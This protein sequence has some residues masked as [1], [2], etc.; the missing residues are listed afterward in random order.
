MMLIIVIVGAIAIIFFIAIILKVGFGGN[1]SLKDGMRLEAQGKLHE[2][3]VAYD[4]IL[5]KGSSSPELRWKIANLALK[6]K[7]IP[8]AQ[9]E[10]NI[11]LGA[12]TLPT[13][14]SLAT[15]KAAM[16]S[17]LI[18]AGNEKQ[19]FMELYEIVKIDDS[20]PSVFLDLGKIYCKQ[21][22]SQKGI[23]LIEKYLS[24]N[25]QDGE[26]ALFLGLAYLDCGLAPK[27]I[28]AFEKALRNKVDD[29]GSANY[30]LGILY[31]SQNKINLA[32][33]H[34]TQV[35]RKKKNQKMVTESHRLIGMCYKE[36]G[37]IDEAITSFE[38]ANV[39]PKDEPK[40]VKTKESLYNHG[41]LLYKKGKYQESLNIFKKIL[42]IDQL[43]KDVRKIIESINNK[44]KGSPSD[45]VV[46][47]IEDKPIDAILKKG[48]LHSSVRFDVDKFEAEVGSKISRD[49][50]SKAK[51]DQTQ[52][53]VAKYSAEKLNQ[54][55]TKDYKEL[56]RKLVTAVGFQIKQEIR[57]QGD[58]EYIDGA[59]INF[60]VEPL[61][62]QGRSKKE[63]VFTLRRYQ[64]EV[65]ELSVSNFLDWIEEKEISQGVFIATNYFSKQAM[66][67]IQKYQHIKFIDKIGLTRML[68]RIR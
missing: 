39:F 59:A 66:S 24:F 43:Y 62:A 19:A 34:F 35:I 3:L 23:P 46:K 56:A 36:K 7:L 16:A 28:E 48:L 14:V 42:L 21:A 44:L 32:L 30:Y 47:F 31:L 2:A 53:S 64:D 4:Y 13:N 54:M 65:S 6:L 5:N 22:K 63:T 41:V 29:D 25:P 10:L 52:D 61:N 15:V 20:I 17:C 50:G 26:A 37:L 1:K 27:A 40:D 8:R 18:S 33:Q 67:I 38:Q 12:K 55:D 68:G 58:T 57:F 45:Y 51:S 60:L 9:K 11:L 49:A